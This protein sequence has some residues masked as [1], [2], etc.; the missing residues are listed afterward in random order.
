MSNSTVSADPLEV[1][2]R[3][4][5]G[6]EAM[7]AEA[8]ASSF[9]DDGVQ[10]MPFSPPGFPKQVQ[11]IDAL[12]QLYRSIAKAFRSIRLPIVR[13]QRFA[14]PSWVLVEF[15]GEF[16]KPDGDYYRNHYFGMF[17][18]VGGKIK[19]YREL[20]DP[21]AFTESISAEERASSFD[22]SGAGSEA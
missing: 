20:Y 8:V 22:T 10:D 17:H 15:K 13:V 1:A 4:L 6:L 19:V 12:R 16:E 7:D 2:R 5:G 11:G 9:A 14:D 18:V 3:Y 21:L